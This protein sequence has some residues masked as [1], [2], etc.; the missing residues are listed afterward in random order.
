MTYLV[1]LDG[2]ED[3]TVRVLLQKGLI[4][5]GLLDTRSHFGGFNDLLAELVNGRVDRLGR[6]DILFASRLEVE[7]LDWRVA[8][9]EVFKG[10]SSLQKGQC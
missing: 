8:H 1:V 5:L 7:L 3:E 10:G 6:R 9:L 4:G 2:E